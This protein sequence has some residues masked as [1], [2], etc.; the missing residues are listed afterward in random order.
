MHVREE[1]VIQNG[2]TELEHEAVERID[3]G[4]QG[5]RISIAESIGG[6]YIFELAK[7]L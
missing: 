5:E 3:V 1:S 6:E 2:Y 4:V 7:Q